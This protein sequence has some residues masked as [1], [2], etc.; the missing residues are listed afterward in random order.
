MS[1]KRIGDLSISGFILSTAILVLLA[2]LV[3]R[4]MS[5]N[6]KTVEEP[7]ESKKKIE[8]LEQRVREIDELKGRVGAIESKSPAPPVKPSGK[9]SRR[10]QG[11]KSKKLW[12]QK[13]RRIRLRRR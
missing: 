8:T 4:P 6:M 9:D 3:F 7:S 12:R 5:K 11:L 13:I 1:D 2:I 10:S